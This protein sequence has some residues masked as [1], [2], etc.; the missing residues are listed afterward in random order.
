MADSQRGGLAE[1]DVDQ[2]IIMLKK[3]AYLL[4]YGRRGKPKFCPFRLSS[5]ESALL[6]HFGKKEKQIELR[7]VTR[8]IPGQRTAIFQRYPRPEK[9]Y[10]SFSLLYNDR[11]LDLICKDKDEAEVW[12][13]GLKALISRGSHSNLRTEA[14]KETIVPYNRLVRRNSV[15]FSDQGDAQLVEGLPGNSLGKAFSELISYTAAA[16]NL[17]QSEPVTNSLTSLSSAAVDN[18]NGRSSAAETFRVSFSSIVSSSSHGSGHED[19]DVLGDVLIWGEGIGDGVLGGGV[20]R[21]GGSSST[22]MNAH[23]P[24]ALVS[25]V[26]LDIHNVACGGRHAVLVTKQGEI[27]SWGEGEGGRLGH[28]VEED[29]SHPKLIDAL[30][31]MNIVLVACGENH[32]CAVTFSGDLYTWG[33]GS[34]NSGLLGHGSNVSHWIPKKLS[35]FMEGIQVSFISCGP[36]HTALVTSAG[37]LFTFG[38]GTFGALGHGDRGCTCVPTEVESLKGLR[39]LRV[40]CG[41]WHTAAVVEVETETSSSG[42]FESSSSGM[43]FTW[44][45][46]DKG[47]LGHGDK[48]PRLVPVLVA[49]LVDVSFCQVACGHNLTIALTT[50]GRVYTMGSTDYGQLGNPLAD[51]KIPTCVE[52]KIADSFVE[53]I[54]CGSYHVAVLTSKTEVY[55]WGK[56][57]NGQL[58]HG[59][60]DNRNTPTLVDFFKDKQVKRVV[61]GVNF[62]AVTCLYRLGSNADTSVCSGCRNPFNFRRK[63]HNCYNCGLAFC[64]ACSIRKALRASLAPSM[65]KPYR[66]CDDCFIKLKNIAESGSVTWMPK[67]KSE[68]SISKANEMSEEDIWGSRLQGQFIRLSSFDSVNQAEGRNSND[69]HVFPLV[70]GNTQW[71]IIFPSKSSNALLEASKNVFSAYVPSF[72]MASQATSPVSTTPTSSRSLYTSEVI[73]GDSKHKNDSPSQEVINLR[74]QV[75]DLTRKSQLLEAE[76]ERSA[77]ELKEATESAAN[78]AEKCK[79]AKEVIKSLTAQLKEMAERVPEGHIAG[80]KL[81]PIVR[82]ALGDPIPT[83]KEGNMM[84]II[85]PRS[86]SNINSSNPFLF[87]GTKTLNEKS[88][89]VVQDEPGVYITLSSLPGGRNELK[90]VRFSRKCFNEEQAEKWWA[91]NEVRV[92]KRHNIRT[93]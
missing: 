68:S 78:E 84:S 42:P 83:S 49:A 87:N 25:T 37:Q 61:C 14:S 71:G 34:H 24:K 36:W 8:I 10:Q 72:R 3:G 48:E 23:L 21:C 88:E 57:A 17:A 40:A 64:K 52:G 91:E 82:R 74:A 15:L 65:N 70:A 90:R 55:T 93:A 66:V 76:I 4:K 41:V 79:A 30:S 26:V 62:T 85:S 29:V 86:E 77:R 39:T 73:L 56:G 60:S 58:G 11:S 45:D 9:E 63:R 33:D 28:G 89:W 20:H 18:S 59:D 7:H 44:G 32:T 27:F 69:T 5:D 54:A 12:L 2:A 19:F 92:C 75:E 46:G 80:K 67:T 1:R 50:T 51:G 31:S 22:K 16:K 53:E 43:L 13:V 35:V 38:D 81:N 6:W 47:R